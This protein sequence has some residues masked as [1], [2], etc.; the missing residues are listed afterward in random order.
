M[1]FLLDADVT[2]AQATVTRLA[3]EAG[4]QVEA[5]TV[6]PSLHRLRTGAAESARGCGWMTVEPRGAQ[7]EVLVWLPEEGV[8]EVARERLEQAFETLEPRTSAGESSKALLRRLRRVEGQV[9]GLQRMI[10]T[11]RECEAVMT[12]FSA[13]SAALRQ[14]AAQLV[15][16]HLTSCIRDELAAGGDTTQ[17]NR[18]LLDILF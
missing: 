10:D 1:E 4:W 8:E 6:E 7:A 2:T 12:Q 18:R 13:V 5:V 17:I 16:E 9:R 11:G 14:T 3:G 15:A